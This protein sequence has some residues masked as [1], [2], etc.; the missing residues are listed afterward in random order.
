MFRPVKIRQYLALMKA[1]GHAAEAVLA[2]SGITAAM[3]EAPG[4]LIDI[5]QSKAIVANMITLS[6]D[7]GIG[8]KI[9]GQ[10]DLVDL[11]LV[12]YSMMS[13]KSLRDTV[14]YWI[15]YSNA[16]IGMPMQV[17][18]EE[19]A[20]DD[21]AFVITES[22]PLGFI[23]NFCV[24]EQLVMICKLGHDL[25]SAKPVLRQLELSYPAPSHHA[26]YRQYFNCPIKFNTRRTRISFSS[27]QLDQPLR[28]N[29]KDFNELCARQC[30]I[31]M[32]QI[33]Q[34]SPLVSKIKNILMRSRGQIPTIEAV[35]AELNLSPR[36]L[37][38]HLSDEGFGYQQLI[39]EFRADLAKE[40]LKS[41]SESA[42]GIAYQLGF[43]EPNSFRRAF[44][45]WT[46]KTVQEYHDEH[47]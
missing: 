29:D 46:G 14:R 11:G 7:Q 24:E 4:F 43:T 21:W 3:I 2:G 44:K 40:Y 19:K 16:L 28:G 13:S 33:S 35:A 18:L 32:R 20:A 31:L 36:T 17:Q 25:T 47:Q 6:D 1:K 37:R 10:T 45:L 8:L 26:L 39:N 42:K 5:D 12:G 34:D 15:N 38:R 30:E 27:P 22:L 41:T 9:G 23:F